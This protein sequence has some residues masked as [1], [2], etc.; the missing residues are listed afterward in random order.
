M[1]DE[2]INKLSEKLQ[3][4]KEPRNHMNQ[5]VKVIKSGIARQDSK[6]SSTVTCDASKKGWYSYRGYKER[7]VTWVRKIV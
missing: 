6:F 1:K 2:E 7:H 5:Q 3:E 4:L